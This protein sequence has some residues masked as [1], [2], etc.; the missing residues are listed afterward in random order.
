[1]SWLAIDQQ[2]GWETLLL[3]RRQAYLVAA[4]IENAEMRGDPGLE[5]DAIVG[6]GAKRIVARLQPVKTHQR[7][8]A[9]GR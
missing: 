3:R 7:K 2:R 5:A 6:R 8:P 9:I 4:E 1:V